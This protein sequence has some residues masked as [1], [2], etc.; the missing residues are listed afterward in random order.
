MTTRRTLTVLLALLLGPSLA[1]AER[2]NP[3]EGQPAIRH[4]VEMRKLRFEVSPSFMTSIN[5]DFRT[6]LGGSVVLQFHINDWLG[7]GAQVG[8]GGAVDTNLTGAINGILPAT[9][10]GQGQALQPSKDQFNSHLADIKANFSV[11]ATV[12]PFAGKL[13]LFGAAF[14]KYDL[15]A[16]A[17]FGGLY[18]A[19]NFQVTN[20]S[21]QATECDAPTTVSSDPNTCSPE[22][23]GFKAGG[24]FGAGVHLYFTDW[25]GVNIELRDFLANINQGGLDVN[26]DRKLNSA[27]ETLANNLFFNVGL[28]FML[29]PTAKVSP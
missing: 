17:G 22:N 23:D 9:E 20:Q 11:Y 12:T 3:L 4:K 5:Q 21:H 13:S 8:F 16:M 7:I 28:T 24:M 26:N 10:T 1:R 27:D 29:P 14:L 19:N 2:K 25:V 18:L 15:Y 6:F